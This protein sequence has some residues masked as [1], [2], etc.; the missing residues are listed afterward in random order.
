MVVAA[1]GVVAAQADD[2]EVARMTAQQ[3]LQQS[4]I[5]YLTDRELEFDDDSLSGTVEAFEPEKRVRVEITDFKFVPGRIELTYDVDC[6][7][8]FAGKIKV[9]ETEHDVKGT[10]DVGAQVDLKATYHDDNGEVIIDAKITDMDEFDVDVVELEPDDLAGGKDLVEKIAGQAFD[11]HKDELMRDVNK[12]MEEQSLRSA[13]HNFTRGHTMTNDRNADQPSRRD[14][15]RAGAGLTA[16][17]LATLAAVDTLFAQTNPLHP[18]EPVSMIGPGQTILFQGDSITDA[19]RKQDDPA[20]NSQPALGNGYAWLA[21]AQLLVDRPERQL[22][23]FN[24]GIS[25]N[26]VY[27]LAE[28]WQADCLDLKPDVLSI[29]IGVNDF[30]HKLKHG[31]DGTL[32]KYETDYRALVKRT[33][34]ALP[35]VKLVI[36]EPFVLEGRRS[37]RLV[38]PRVRRLSRGGEARGRRSGRDVRAVSNDV[39]RRGEDR[40]AATLGRRRRPSHAR[41]RGPHGPLVAAVGRRVNRLRPLVLRCTRLQVQLDPADH[42]RR[43]I[44]NHRRN[45]PSNESLTP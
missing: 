33:K 39:R 30:W 5:E 13:G 36:C 19:G 32:E 14:F 18:T 45:D 21:A 12:W 31:Y 40:P 9:E 24:R 34:D 6:R 43:D 2:A 20:A 3:L 35:N 8:R 11:D 41:R 7:F 15:V 17:S 16:A 22:K 42:A 26:K 4:T 37:R 10:A 28:R 44:V 25:G 38:V 29:L 23:I 27:Q 1:F